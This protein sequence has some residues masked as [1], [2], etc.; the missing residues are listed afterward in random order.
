M[1]DVVQLVLNFQHLFLKGG[2]IIQRASQVSHSEGLWI[3]CDN[4]FEIHSKW[5]GGDRSIPNV[6][7]GY[8]SK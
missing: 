4:T 8:S 2:R 5:E 1:I 3:W 6:R 7:V